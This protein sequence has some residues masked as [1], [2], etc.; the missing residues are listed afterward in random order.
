VHQKG[1]YNATTDSA[2]GSR[3]IRVLS[4]AAAEETTLQTIVDPVSGRKKKRLLQSERSW[5]DG[6]THLA[7]PK[8]TLLW[9]YSEQERLGSNHFLQGGRLMKSQAC[10]TPTPTS[11]HLGER[12]EQ[13]ATRER[14]RCRAA[15]PEVPVVGSEPSRSKHAD[16][17]PSKPPSQ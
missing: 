15:G 14:S 17:A 9:L 2:L 3:S 10:P 11:S 6:T 7:A 8:A 16:L 4:A 1:R 12:I 13:E 5:K